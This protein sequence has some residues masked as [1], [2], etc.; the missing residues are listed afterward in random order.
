MVSHHP[1]VV[2]VLELLVF[3]PGSMPFVAVSQPALILGVLVQVVAAVVRLPAHSI[4]LLWMAMF[5][6]SGCAWS[7][8]L[9]RAKTEIHLFL[10]HMLF[11]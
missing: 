7:S 1:V 11:T 4:L 3:S 5:L 8:S 10:L 6:I 9:L 2:G